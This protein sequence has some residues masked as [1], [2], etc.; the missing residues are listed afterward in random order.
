MEPT[1]SSVYPDLVLSISSDLL[2]NKKTEVFDI[3]KK[4]DEVKYR[5]KIMNLGNEFKMHHFHALDIEI[6]GKHKELNEIIIK[7]SSLP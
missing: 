6:T 2:K 5:A 7:E 3:M 4:G 1:E